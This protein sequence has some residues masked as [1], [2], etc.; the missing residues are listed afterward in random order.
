M[1]RPASVSVPPA[2]SWLDSAASLKPPLDRWSVPRIQQLTLEPQ[3]LQNSVDLRQNR[4][5]LRRID[6]VAGA[7]LSADVGVMKTL[8]L[9]RLRNPDLKPLLQ[10]SLWV[11]TGDM[12]QLDTSQLALWEQ[13]GHGITSDHH[14]G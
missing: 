7:P 6:N 14:Q 8:G 13:V 12:I 2:S 9:L 10:R 1:L 3:H 4:S 11:K 5:T